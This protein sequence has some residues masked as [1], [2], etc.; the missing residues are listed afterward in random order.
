MDRISRRAVLKSLG[1]IGFALTPLQQY[2]ARAATQG[3][4]PQDLTPHWNGEP[5]GRITFDDMNARAEPNVNA[6]VLNILKRDMVVPVREAIVGQ[7]VFLNNDLW[8]E[9]PYG[10]LY[11]SYVQ[12]MHYYLPQTPRA[13]LGEGMW[14]EV[15]VPFSD[16]YWDTT[17]AD[18]ERL[19][20]RQTHK[21]VYYLKELVKGK[22]G[23]SW[24]L[25]EEPYQ[26]YYMRATHLRIIAPEEMSPISPEVDPRDK[27]VEVDLGK[28]LVLCYE[29]EQIVFAA[30]ASTGA[31]DFGTPRGKFRIHD[32][33]AGTRMIGGSASDNVGDY[34]LPG[35]P[36]T[37]YFTGDWAAI[38]G[39]YW[40][41]DFGI[42]RSHGC[43]NLPPDASR[44]IWRWTT[45]YVD[46]H[47]L[48][49]QIKNGY[50]GTP[51]IVDG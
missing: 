21:S 40:H 6:E 37:A 48:V 47:A 39:A 50:E 31:G 18:P 13:D 30:R 20:S 8:L 26:S 16:A 32:K 33:R 44:W 10:Y 17:D 35:V 25:V 3:G 5:F 43:V 24:Y 2:T 36:F 34:D 38:H 15:I 28:Q 11:S 41:N 27:R 51:V 14:A 42:P 1:L 46:Y 23:K 19:V 45:P 49:Y 9:T 4:S 7:H 22:D 29:K 12:P